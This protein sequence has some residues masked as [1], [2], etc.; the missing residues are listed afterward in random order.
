[1]N[2]CFSVCYTSLVTV[3]SA[4]MIAFD[5]CVQLYSCFLEREFFFITDLFYFV[6]MEVGSLP[7]LF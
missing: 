5:Y 6:M 7:T 1:M 3:Q 2:K 4:E